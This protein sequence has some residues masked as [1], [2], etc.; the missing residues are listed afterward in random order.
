MIIVDTREQEEEEAYFIR[1][2]IEFRREALSCGDYSAEDSAGNR[3]VIERKEMSDLIQS[4]FEGRL[5]SQLRR[6]SLERL[7]ILV[8][9]GRIEDYWERK[10][11]SKFTRSHLYGIISSA[12]VRYG[13]R[14]V[15]WAQTNEDA[16][17]IIHKMLIKITE[18]KLD[19]IPNR[20][21]KEYSTCVGYLRSL[22]NCTQDT[23]L[24]L[25]KKFKNIRGIIDASDEQLQE[26]KNVGP[27]KVARLRKIIDG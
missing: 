17:G 26:I 16:L 3:V 22:L 27:K 18:N 15:I 14:C 25:L 2:E 24:E 5:E 9:S 13:L 21:T 11:D 23:A 19:K 7:P 12:I 10:K 4:M 8:I 6:L 1:N 20:K